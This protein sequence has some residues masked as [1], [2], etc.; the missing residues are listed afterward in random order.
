MPDTEELITRSIQKSAA[1]S[2]P[3]LQPETV[4]RIFDS[5]TSIHNQ[6]SA[7]GIP[8]VLLASPKVR[9]AM[10]NLISYNFPDLTV[11]SLNEVPNDIPIETVGMIEG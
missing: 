1:G 9:P 8:H 7:R 3:I 10:K 4:T 6:L 2:I 11:V 5:I